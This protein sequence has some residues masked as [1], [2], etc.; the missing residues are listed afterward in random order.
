[1]KKIKRKI[2]GDDHSEMIKEKGI[3]VSIKPLTGVL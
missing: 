1:M 2:K 3:S